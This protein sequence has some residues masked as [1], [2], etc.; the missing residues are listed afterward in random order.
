MRMTDTIMIIDEVLDK[1][2]CEMLIKKFEDAEHVAR[3]NEVQLFDEVN[4]NQAGWNWE[5]ERIILPIREIFLNEYQMQFPDYCFPKR[6]AYEESRMKRYK[7]NEG[8]FSK[9][10]DVGDYDSARRFLV[11]FY[12]LNDVEDGGETVFYFDK[13]IK[14][15]PKAG[16]LIMFP[17]MWMYP[18]AGT[19]PISNNKYIVGTY[20]HYI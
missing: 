6:Y 19:M 15:K 13:E 8:H 12:Y 5:L 4:L 14:V 2:F 3:N 1:T 10:V 9:H 7:A 16:R 11:A 20:L 17:P 18:H